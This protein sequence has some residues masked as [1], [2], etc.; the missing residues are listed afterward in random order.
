MRRKNNEPKGKGQRK[1]DV[2]KP[3]RHSL[4][5]NLSTVM[6]PWWGVAGQSV[7]GAQGFYRAPYSF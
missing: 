5:S 4:L 2:H 6:H 3:Q 1:E 7:W